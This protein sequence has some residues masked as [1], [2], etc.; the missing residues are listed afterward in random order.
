MVGSFQRI[1]R[2]V[3]DRAIDEP[4]ANGIQH[5]LM[6]GHGVYDAVRIFRSVK[7]QL[8]RHNTVQHR[9][10]ILVYQTVK[11]IIAKM[12]RTGFAGKEPVGTHK[13]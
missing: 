7:G 4:V 13:V 8:W 12:E 11:R 10:V 5:R 6:L 3:R 1:I 9:H 2:N